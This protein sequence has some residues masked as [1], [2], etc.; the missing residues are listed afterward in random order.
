MKELDNKPELIQLLKYRPLGVQKA[1]TLGLP[2]QMKDID[3]ED[4]EGFEQRIRGYVKI[5]N[6]KGIPAIAG[7]TEKK[8]NVEK[9]DN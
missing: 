8:P 9:N 7:S 5:L 2:M 3:I 6:D 1:K 4:K